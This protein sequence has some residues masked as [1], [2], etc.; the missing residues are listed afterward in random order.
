MSEGKKIK[1]L[2]IFRASLLKNSGTPLRVHNILANL[3]KYNDI[4][5]TTASADQEPVFDCPHIYLPN[6]HVSDLK[7]LYR[8]VKDNKINVVIGHTLGTYIYLLPLWILTDA[9]I[10]LEQHGFPEE[11]SLMYNGKKGLRYYF[12]KFIYHQI[13]R[14]CDLITTCS[15]T[16]TETIKPFNKNTVT[17]FGS[18]DLKLFN[19]HVQPSSLVKRNPGDI[20]IGYAGNARIWQGWDFL[21]DAFKEIQK[22]D[23]SFKIYAAISETKEIQLPEGVTRVGP[24]AYEHVPHF[25]A[26]CDILII[27][28]LQNTV[29]YLSFPSKLVEYMAMGKPVVASKTSD[30]HKVIQHQVDGI[31]YDPGDIEGCKKSVLQL[32]DPT[33]RAQLGANAYKKVQEAFTWEKQTET[34]VSHIRKLFT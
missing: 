25:L 19:P 21:M 15:E 23:S 13:F 31:L 2:S 27:P 4:E 3:K 34:I 9:K 24:L 8:Y 33:L 30:M 29:N 16:A 1:I 17:V 22:T 5:L 14:M 7:T 12:D 26:E 18:A 32:K 28:R 20:I 6:N 10:V 11:E